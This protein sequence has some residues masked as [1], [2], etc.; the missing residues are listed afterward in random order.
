LWIVDLLIHRKILRLARCRD[1]TP[2]IDTALGSPQ[3]RPS[4]SF[5]PPRV[6][7]VLALC[8]ASCSN[9][10]ETPPS[11][12]QGGA[13]MGGASS[14]AGSSSTLGG[15]DL[16]GNG[17]VL[18]AGANL[19]GNAGTPS[20]S[21]VGGT[22]GIGGAAAPSGGT[23]GTPTASGGAESAG[24]IGLFC[25]DF[26]SGKLDPAVWTQQ[27]NGGQ[28]LKVQ[29]DVVAHGK[30]AVQFHG[31]PNVVSYDF[32]IA[33]N[34]PASLNGHHFGRAYFQVTPKPPEKHT[35]FLFAGTSGFPKLKYLEV[36]ESGLGW[37]LTYVQQVAPTGETYTPA[38]GSLPLAKWSCLE[39]EMNDT[40]DQIRVS[41]DGASAVKFD[42]ITFM[43]K[44]SGL[45]GGF[46]DFGFGFYI[47][48]PATYVFDVYYDDIVLDTKPIGCL[49]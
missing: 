13:I 28:T 6:F 16:A 25:E 46:T 26:E 5:Q 30:H 22:A 49:P 37:Q 48:H 15:S 38:T 47:W 32:I 8:A 44:S 11:N 33:R 12:G 7:C 21:G 9:A 41:V 20:V 29:T 36:A 24:C 42:D 4:M 1:F 23:G 39:W 27:A 45:V 35:E 19:G 43:G 3:P 10:V 17:G 34:V 14:D 40:P 18:V 2:Y 31:L